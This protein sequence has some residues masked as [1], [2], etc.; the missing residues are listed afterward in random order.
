[1]KLSADKIRV[2]AQKRV[3]AQNLEELVGCRFKDL[4]KL[5]ERIEFLTG[6]TVDAIAESQT[7]NFEGCDFMIDFCCE[8]NID[9]YTIFYLKDNAGNYYITEV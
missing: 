9:I 1:M 6:E 4:Q 5:K 7:E 2:I 3:F 8:E